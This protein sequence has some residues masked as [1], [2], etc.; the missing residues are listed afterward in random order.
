MASVIALAWWILQQARRRG[1]KQ[2]N[3]RASTDDNLS[4]ARQAA[5]SPAGRWAASRIALASSSDPAV[6]EVRWINACPEGDHAAY[7]CLNDSGTYY[8]RYVI[9]FA[10]GVSPSVFAAGV[11]PA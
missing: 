6:A 5:V 11:S 4:A 1:Q 8:T 3:V 2:E 7:T 10:A 9:V